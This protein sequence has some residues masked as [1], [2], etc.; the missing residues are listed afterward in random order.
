MLR[1]LRHLHAW[2]VETCDDRVIGHV[3]DFRL[4]H[5]RWIARFLVVKATSWVPQR[6]IL[7]PT[8]QID[9]IDWDGARI[10]TSMTREDVRKIAANPH[11]VTAPGA[12]PTSWLHS[13][14]GTRGCHI[15]ALDGRIGCVEDLLA[16][17]DHWGIPYLAVDTSQW[18]GGS[19]LVPSEW[20][21]RVDSQARMVHVNRLRDDLKS[22]LATRRSPWRGDQN[23][24]VIRNHDASNVNASARSGSS[25]FN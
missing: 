18:I 24:M 22:S 8:L 1:R 6:Q 21:Q 25:R 2:T 5:R 4:D 11:W 12:E 23:C 3:D 15:Q 19:V 20:T 10:V 14:Q 9:G 16:D 13:V 7:I 17:D